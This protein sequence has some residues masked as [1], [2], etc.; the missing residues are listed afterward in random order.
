[1]VSAPDPMGQ[2]LLVLQIV[3]VKCSSAAASDG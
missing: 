3:M 2:M 1:M